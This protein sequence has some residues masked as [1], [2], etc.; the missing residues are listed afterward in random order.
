MSFP[1]KRESSI[2]TSN[3]MKK[4][5]ALSLFIFWALVAAL[6]TSGLV[7]YQNN[8]QVKAPAGT[9]QA[10]QAG[11]TT[12]TQV[13]SIQ[14]IAK[15]NNA[16]SCW[17]LIEGKVYDV[18]LYIYQHPGNADTI[19]PTCGTDATKAYNTKGKTSRPSPH[20]QN[21]YEL[22]KQFYI[23]DL[24]QAPTVVTPSAT[25][26]VPTAPAAQSKPTAPIT[27]TTNS[28]ITLSSQEVA[29][30]NTTADCWLIINNNVYNVTSYLGQHPGGVSTIKPSCGKDG[31][32]L[33]E[34]LPHSTNAHQLLANFYVG[35]FGQK[36]TTQTIQKTVA[37]A[38]PAGTGRG[39]IEN[40]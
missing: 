3:S 29:K 28:T 34:G 6:L 5:T 2:L 27:S 40:D 12:L 20:S 19:I 30:H 37:P 8:Q 7:F 31:T 17:L 33:F 18:S 36:T 11:A 14:E 39:E 16:S 32:A 21:A 35:A 1:Q 9:N 15:H 10:Q 25:Q 24:G 22:L 38:L 23:G 26:P 4:L 13:L